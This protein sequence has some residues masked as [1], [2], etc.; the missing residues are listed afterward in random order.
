MENLLNPI[1]MEKKHLR[2]WLNFNNNRQSICIFVCR[3]SMMKLYRQYVLSCVFLADYPRPSEKRPSIY[4]NIDR[5]GW[6]W[7]YIILWQLYK[8]QY[9]FSKTNQITRIKHS[10]QILVQ[11][12]QN[13]SASRSFKSIISSRQ[14]LISIIILKFLLLIPRARLNLKLLCLF[15]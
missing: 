1:W 5:I 14:S 13:S 7:Y 11:E 12:N 8:G 6:H 4:S 3:F 10:L 9:K 15:W 2:Y